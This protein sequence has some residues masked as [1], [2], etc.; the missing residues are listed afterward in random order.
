[1]RTEQRVET[2]TRLGLTSNQAKAYL[3]LVQF[4]PLI[5]KELAVR[6]HITR[7]DIYR[8]VPEL[9]EAGIVQKHIDRPCVYRAIPIDQGTAILLKRNMK[10]QQELRK[11]V[12]ELTSDLKN[13]KVEPGNGRENPNFLMIHGREA[14]I[15]RLM[16]E[17][18]RIQRSLDVVTSSVRFSSSIN[19]FADGYACALK[20]GVKIRIAA[21]LHAPEKSALSI[22]KSLARDSGFEV[23]YFSGSPDA[24][25][26]LFDEELA[27]ITLSSVAHLGTASALWS[28]EKS[29]VA[30]AKSY[31]E[32]KWNK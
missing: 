10:Q 27:S 21:E 23:R 11:K 19:A 28:N 18:V 5:A 9:E 32:S 12:R 22:I 31:F 7:Q 29:F 25:V 14:I 8:V 16:E 24:V 13:S 1:L 17:L 15:Q 2:L 3:A 26:S 20:R 4:G 30:L 6:S